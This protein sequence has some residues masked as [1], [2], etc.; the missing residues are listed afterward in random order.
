[1][2]Q[3]IVTLF[4]V[5]Y[6]L[7]P[8]EWPLGLSKLHFVQTTMIAGLVL[9][10]VRDRGLRIRDLF[11]TPH[12]WMVLF[13][14]LWIVVSSPTPWDSFKE[15]LNLYVFY[16]VIVQTLYTV[17]RIQRFLWW[18]TL[19]IVAVAGL[20]LASLYGFDPLSSL[21]LTKG[22]MKERLVLNL[23]IFNN[24]NA[25]GH[26]VVPA[27]PM[28]YYV[29]IWK[30][31]MVMKAIGLTLTAV[32]LDCIFLTVSKGAFIAGAVTI[33]ATLTFGRP[34][35]V[36]ALI[37]SG[38]LI[39][40]GSILY[41]LPRMQELQKSKTDDAIQGRVIAFKHGY[42]M[43][44]TTFHGVGF[45]QW[46][47]SFLAA[48]YIYKP[49]HTDKNTSKRPEIVDKAPHSSY[50]GIGG[51]LGYPGF[52]L[53]LG[54]LYCSLRTLATAR[55][56]STEEESIRR[57]LFVLIV[58]YMVSSWMVDFDYRPTFFMFTAATAALHRHLLALGAE[59]D[60]REQEAEE[61][62]KFQPARPSWRAP[63]V[64][65]PAFA[66]ALASAGMPAA[67]F[68]LGPG[69]EPI[70]NLQS[71]SQLSP[72]IAFAWNRIGWLDVALIL[73]M[74][75]AALRYWTYVMQRM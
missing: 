34:K 48:H 59:K 56:I 25:L 20:A 32:A 39:F 18:W 16:I 40:G 6:Y 33:I 8:Q 50:V 74:T 12:D 47:R 37:I 52:I 65:Q 14:W 28:A 75:Y 9:L 64:Q 60:A 27:I 1:M 67:A 72:R 57:V 42:R 4:L 38:A 73:L 10:F 7:R 21:E 54:I 45:H 2:D 22:S 43:L 19:L 62:H 3:V 68:T 24:P 55:T 36:Q 69:P 13:F 11:Q 41:A 30:R 35:T 46:R 66:G 70:P 49:K 53:F 51:E 71:H 23:S 17:P 29:F 31:P 5:F 61:D 44:T 58:S 26:S 15:S 63:L